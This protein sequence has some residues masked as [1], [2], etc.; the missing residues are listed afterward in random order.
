LLKR[1]F[2]IDLAHCPN[3]GGQLE[4]IVVIL[5]SA[6][7]LAVGKRYLVPRARRYTAPT[8]DRSGDFSSAADD[9]QRRFASMRC[10]AQ[11]GHGLDNSA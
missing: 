6:W 3:C 4:I 5:E 7:H 9:S 2:A 8:L 11:T 1:V 10:P